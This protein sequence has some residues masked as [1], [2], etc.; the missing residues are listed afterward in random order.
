MD[1]YG[2]RVNKM[3]TK[4]L[5]CKYLSEDNK[6]EEVTI[7]SIIDIIVN[8]I[9]IL[10]GAGFIIFILFC[11]TLTVVNPNA[12]TVQQAIYSVASAWV[13]IVSIIIVI[14]LIAYLYVRSHEVIIA[15][16]EK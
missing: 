4:K 9:T 2:R 16:C 8:T 3:N 6:H 13:S 12:Q 11:M 1:I 10:F 5:L 14:C 15:K 7:G